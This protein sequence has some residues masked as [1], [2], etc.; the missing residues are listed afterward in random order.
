MEIR[1][2]IEGVILYNKSRM[3]MNETEES[4]LSS[5]QDKVLTP[6]G[7]ECKVYRDNPEFKEVTLP[8]LKLVLASASLTA[9]KDS[10]LETPE[11]TSKSGGG[12]QEQLSDALLRELTNI[13]FKKATGKYTPFVFSGDVSEIRF[14][15]ER[16]MEGRS[17]DMFAK[18]MVPEKHSSEMDKLLTE[19]TKNAHQIKAISKELTRLA[20]RY[21]LASG[22]SRYLLGKELSE[23]LEAK[24]CD[25]RTGPHFSD[26][27]KK[28]NTVNPELEGTD[29][30]LFDMVEARVPG[31]NKHLSDLPKAGCEGP[32]PDIVSPVVDAMLDIGRLRNDQLFFILVANLKDRTELALMAANM[33]GE[34][35]P[36]TDLKGFWMTVVGQAGGSPYLDSAIENLEKV[37]GEFDSSVKLGHHQNVGSRLLFHESDTEHEQR[38]SRLPNKAEGDI[39]HHQVRTS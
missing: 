8:E 10:L 38:G 18:A 4:Q 32:V 28:Y 21:Q 26:L 23:A 37:L 27:E 29:L 1:L 7:P 35:I 3:D 13:L 22:K 19:R 31:F 36:D 2:S 12:P 24:K 20:S 30:D 5:D 16:M 39:V 33:L 25:Y 9:K 15:L 6:R 11:R 34:E 17:L 14:F